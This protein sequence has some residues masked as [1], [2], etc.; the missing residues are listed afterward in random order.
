MN[1]DMDENPVK[2]L[3]DTNIIISALGFGGKPREI[4][5]LVLD[6]QIKAITSSILLAEL[7]D[8]I[9][10]KFPLLS[11]NFERINKQI[12][13][14]FKIVKPKVSLHIIK[15]EDDN[16][17]L[18]AAVEGMCDYIITGDNEL[19]ELSL[20]KN[21]KIVSANQFLNFFFPHK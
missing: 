20:F 10:K 18:E 21:I 9:T 6:K 7:E 15:D 13:K 5:Q 11:T 19:L 8:V 12:R 16:R 3:L 17:V 4:L 1:T 14:K 2:V